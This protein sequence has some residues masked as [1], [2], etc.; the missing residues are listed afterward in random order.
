[1]A[2]THILYG[3][4]YTVYIYKIYIYIAVVIHSSFQVKKA[5]R[6]F[7]N[8]PLRSPKMGQLSLVEHSFVCPKAKHSALGVGYP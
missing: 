5:Y 8:F 2:Y 3:L 6:G 7:T 4:M 1:M